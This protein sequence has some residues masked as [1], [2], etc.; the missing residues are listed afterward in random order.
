[1]AKAEQPVITF[2]LKVVA[3]VN[4]VVYSLQGK[5]GAPVDPRESSGADINFEFAV[6]L[7]ANAHGPCVLGDFVRT[8]G[9]TR[10]FFY[11]A[12]GGQTGQ[13]GE[14]G[15]RAKVDFPELTPDLVRKAEAGGLV[16]E[17]AMQGADTKGE[18]ACAT[19]KLV[20]GWKASAVKAKASP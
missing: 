15:R 18:P 1:M 9:K 20:P 11:V 10:R 17:A 2:R 19:I 14:G 12:T 4:G 16:L 13:S 7:G 8:E 5:A 6:R 3:P